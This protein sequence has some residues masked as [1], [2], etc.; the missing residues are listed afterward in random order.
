MSTATQSVNYVDVIKDI[1]DFYSENAVN[2]F[3]PVAGTNVKFTP[4]TVQQFR[5]FIE[6]QVATEKDEFGVVPGLQVVR[7][8][9]DVL[10]SNCPEYGDKLLDSLT[11]LDRDAIIVQLR[12]YT[13]G[14]AE[15]VTT[16]EETQTVDLLE[17]VK[18][19]KSTKFSAKLKTR[20]KQFKYASGSVNVKM[21]LP[22][23]RTDQDVNDRFRERVLPKIKK[24]RKHVEKEAEKI[25][26]QVYFLEICKYIDTVTVTKKDSNTV[27]N[28]RDVESFDNNFALLERL[29]TTVI[30]EVSSY[31]NDIRKY[32]DSVFSYVNVDDKDVPLDVDIALFAGI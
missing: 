31:M 9:N 24:G 1:E 19:L 20:T 22:T 10:I 7:E 6:L 25:L 29:P 26:S 27:L 2:A 30:S 12:A 14:E 16:E 21:Q 11:V 17:I 18:K 13:K 3:C 23:L 32:R 4:I 28:F 15:V 8:I 5:K